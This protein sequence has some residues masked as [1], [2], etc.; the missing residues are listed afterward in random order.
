MDYEIMDKFFD[1]LSSVNH[2]PT[3]LDT[4][5]SKDFKR[6]RCPEASN[7]S[8][9]DIAI[10]VQPDKAVFFC[11]HCGLNKTISLKQRVGKKRSAEEVYREAVTVQNHDYLQLKDIN[12]QK[13]LRRRDDTLLIPL[14]KDEKL[15]S[16][17]SI[18]KD[19][20]TGRFVKKFLKGH[21]VKGAYYKFEGNENKILICEGFATGSTLHEA[22]G[23][24]V[25]CAMSSGN[26]ISVADDLKEKYELS[27]LV[28]AADND[29]AGIKSA[30]KTNLVWICPD[31]KGEDFNDTFVSLLTR[32]G[33]TRNK[34]NRHERIKE[35]ARILTNKLETKKTNLSDEP[36]IPKKYYYENDLLMFDH[37]DEPLIVSSYVK[38]IAQQ[39]DLYR[40]DDWGVTIE[41]K[42][43]I[44]RL[45]QTSLP[46]DF[47]GNKITAKQ[48]L[49]RMGIII[50]D[51][52]L[53]IK[54]LDTCMPKKTLKSVKKV[55]WHEADGKEF[56]F[57]GK[58]ALGETAKNVV[59]ESEYHFSEYNESESLDKWNQHVA[60]LAN[61]SEIAKF[62]MAYS[63]ASI[64]NKEAP[65]MSVGLNLY[66]SSSTGKSTAGYLCT[67]IW[68]D[69][70][71]FNAAN[72]TGFNLETRA[73]LRN[74]SVLILDDLKQMRKSAADSFIY[75]LSNGEAGGRYNNKEKETFRVNYLT[76]YEGTIDE[77][78]R[79]HNLA[80]LGGHTVR[81]ID[82]DCNRGP[83]G[84]FNPKEGQ[85]YKE[86]AEKI[87]IA[88]RKYYGAP[89]RRFI[90]YY[91]E[92]NI[93]DSLHELLDKETKYLTD[94]LIE[95]YGSVGSQV[96]RVLG[97]FSR[98]IVAYELAQKAGID[99][100]GDI[101]HTAKDILVDY[102][103]NR[104]SPDNIESNNILD[105]ARNFM[106]ENDSR[107]EKDRPDANDPII[108]KALGF[109]SKING[110]TTYFITA[111]G[112][113]ELCGDISKKTAIKSL[114]KA[115]Y[116]MPINRG[117]GTVEA[118]TRAKM[119]GS[120][121][122][123]RGYHFCGVNWL[124]EE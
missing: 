24:T 124:K 116:L 123:V 122:W 63:L 114:I 111:A 76:T 103:T 37:K 8:N 71:F 35:I 100:R 89:A 70:S 65:G 95:K 92:N 47:T 3:N 109:K 78:L 86:L 81:V 56:Y 10:A 33:D 61:D 12:A 15:V 40:D 51:I 85:N 73:S 66:G 94:F 101:R 23:H 68:G 7:K 31:E 59:F 108:H 119:P 74:D 115:G 41:Y 69:R 121:I 26:I 19:K 44:G 14:Y 20:E 72:C 58:E 87:D 67:S 52:K 99:F 55:G 30:K 2:L 32:N 17:Q 88:T 83:H 75:M 1:Y 104:E 57:K 105:Q 113:K 38:V 18:Y 27:Q 49:S 77:F 96:L 64:F 98:T 91:I 39:V 29:D 28:V 13:D 48:T 5:I 46:C 79:S 36:I 90:E 9:L 45:K 42:D 84:I 25:Y 117:D 50:H 4:Q 93:K 120:G 22:S 60:E 53:L 118:C 54:F 62:G 21:S 34:N 110:G 82:I 11:W 97:V 106:A 112:F 6:Y 16:I 43:R 80:T 107:F 102:I